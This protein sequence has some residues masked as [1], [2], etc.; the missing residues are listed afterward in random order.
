MKIYEIHTQ[1]Y[2]IHKIFQSWFKF[3]KISETM[4]HL[5]AQL[6]I[7]VEK[8]HIQDM[9][10]IHAQKR[11]TF[12]GGTMRRIGPRRRGRNWSWGKIFTPNESRAPALH[13]GMLT[14]S[15]ECLDKKIWPFVHFSA[16]FYVRI[17]GNLDR[18]NL[19]QWALNRKF[20]V[21]SVCNRKGE[22]FLVPPCRF[23]ILMI[24]MQARNE[25]FL[26]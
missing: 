16:S 26:L 4:Y 10:Q 15:R 5:Y 17:P 22:G 2:E 14:S 25:L 1:I 12:L 13:V 6:P 23:R 8:P 20:G 24:L 9:A 19:K 21:R 3:P 11:G 7:V 18:P